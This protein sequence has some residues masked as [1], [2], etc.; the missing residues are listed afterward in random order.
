MSCSLKFFFCVHCGNLA[1]L[2]QNSG[3]PMVCCGEDMLELVPNTVDA[4]KEKHVPVAIN[5]DACACGCTC[6]CAL[7]VEVGSEPHP[8]TEGHH[9]SFICVETES[10]AT[11]RC[12][13]VGQEPSAEF[14]CCYN[15]PVAVYAYCNLHGLWKADIA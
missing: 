8:M 11:R 5:L 9:I 6:G 13:K 10:G 14:C 1:E 3:V 2:V 15:K 12:L 4:S 7:K